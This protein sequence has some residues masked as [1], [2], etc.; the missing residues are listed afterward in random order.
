M[1][2]QPNSTPLAA[3][4][5]PFPDT[6]DDA[7]DE[8]QLQLATIACQQSGLKPDGSWNYS[9]W[10]SAKDHKVSHMT[11]SRCLD[12]KSDLLLISHSSLIFDA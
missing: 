2:S 7:P 4:N 8:E 1:E 3:A 6:L 12:G 5:I 9:I 10:Q 11:L